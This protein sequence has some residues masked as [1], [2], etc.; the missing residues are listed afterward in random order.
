M[1][2]WKTMLWSNTCNMIAFLY[3][4]YTYICVYANIEIYI[5][6]TSDE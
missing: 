2:Y 3:M 4:L 5:D 6:A 1:V